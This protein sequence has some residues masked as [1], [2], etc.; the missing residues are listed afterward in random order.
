MAA[1]QGQKSAVPL[2]NKTRD[3]CSLTAM[4]TK[5]PNHSN[6]R[7]HACRVE[8]GDMSIKS[9]CQNLQEGKEHTVKAPAKRQFLPKHTYPHTPTKGH[10]G[11]TKHLLKF[12][13]FETFHNSCLVRSVCLARFKRDMQAKQECTYLFCYIALCGWLARLG[14]GLAGRVL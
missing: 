9:S 14:A 5:L 4:E 12:V 8:N 2:S 13:K 1:R 10:S 7:M 3:A 6:A 11:D